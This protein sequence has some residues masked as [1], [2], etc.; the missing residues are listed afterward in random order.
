MHCFYNI[1]LKAPDKRFVCLTGAKLSCLF[2]FHAVWAQYSSWYLAKRLNRCFA[3]EKAV[4]NKIWA[5]LKC[6]FVWFLFFA[7]K[8][9]LFCELF[10]LLYNDNDGNNKIVKENGPSNKDPYLNVLNCL[11]FL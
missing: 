3:K 7:F 5:L 9:L 1:Y 2:Q 10:L 4:G 8:S 6:S 11:T